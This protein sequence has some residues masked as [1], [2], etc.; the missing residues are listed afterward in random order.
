[1]FVICERLKES[2]VATF[3][4][5]LTCIIK[6]LWNVESLSRSARGLEV[7]KLLG[8]IIKRLTADWVWKE[9]WF[10]Q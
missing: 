5:F 6:I 9:K 7:E 1:M 2:P 10:Q 8:L 3:T 4:N